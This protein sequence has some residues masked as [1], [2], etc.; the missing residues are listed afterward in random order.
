MSMSFNPGDVR[1][2]L[3][4]VHALTASGVAYAR[5]LSGSIEGQVFLGQNVVSKFDLKPG[6]AFTGRVV[7]NYPDRQEIVPWRLIYV[8]HGAT[9]S[10]APAPAAKSRGLTREEIEAR[11]KDTVLDGR[12]WTSREVFRSVFEETFEDALEEAR[13]RHSVVVDALVELSRTGELQRAKLY[14]EDVV[15][16]IYYSTDI[17]ALTPDGYK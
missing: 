1:E 10:P 7:P 9:V 6:D 13:S 16:A 3:F 8:N 17:D 15:I 4:V 5:S 12:V 2:D 14:Q 11:V